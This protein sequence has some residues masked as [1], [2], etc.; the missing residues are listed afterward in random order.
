MGDLAS[1]RPC[2][3]E[4]FFVR[5]WER[6]TRARI[7]RG[8]LGKANSRTRMDF[9][10]PILSLSPPAGEVGEGVVPSEAE[11]TTEGN[12]PDGVVEEGLTRG[13]PTG[14]RGRA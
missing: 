3:V 2:D 8:R 13:K 4:K 1:R 10:F 5:N 6:L 9:L 7:V 11:R 12:L 14:G